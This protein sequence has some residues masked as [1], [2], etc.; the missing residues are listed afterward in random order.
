MV[1]CFACKVRGHSS[2]LP[3]IYYTVRI[4]LQA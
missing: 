1:M 2:L 3:A 4:N